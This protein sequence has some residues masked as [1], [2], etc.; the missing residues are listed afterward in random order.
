[1]R[2]TG[3]LIARSDLGHYKIGVQL[4][5]S[6]LLTQDGREAALVPGDL[7]IYDTARPYTLAFDDPYRQ[8]VLM[9]PRRLLHLP[10]E[11]VAGTTATKTARTPN[12]KLRRMQTGLF[13]N[14]EWSAAADGAE[15]TTHD[16]ATGRELATC[17]QAGTQDV[18]KAVEAA[19]AALR[20]PDWMS[21]AP[22]A[23]A[24][25]LWRV[26]DLIEEHGAELAEL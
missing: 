12:T 21:M 23:R 26:A 9:L 19:Q 20:A 25:L 5:G 8:L 14:G 11:A 2:R 3:P 13:I 22:T 7:T 10:E 4:G 24:R 16:P 17:A 1:M 15:F 6:C 18:E